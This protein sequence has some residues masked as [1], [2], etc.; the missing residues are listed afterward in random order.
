MLKAFFFA[1]FANIFADFE[2]RDRHF[3]TVPPFFAK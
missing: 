2:S 1:Y 3:Y